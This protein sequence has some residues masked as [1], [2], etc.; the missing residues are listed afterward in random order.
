MFFFIY[1]F[2]YLFTYDTLQYNTLLTILFTYTTTTLPTNY[3][4]TLLSVFT[5]LVT[6]KIT[7]LS[8]HY[9]DLFIPMYFEG[10]PIHSIEFFL[11]ITV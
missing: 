3:I 7:I 5:I 10:F 9:S 6:D 8:L 1:L 11:K 4:H 2:I